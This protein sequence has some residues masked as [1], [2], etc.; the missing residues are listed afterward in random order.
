MRGLRYLF[1]AFAVVGVMVP[2]LAFHVDAGTPPYSLFYS[3]S[4]D[5][6][7]KEYDSNEIAADAKFKGKIVVVSGTIRDIGKGILGEA[8]VIIGGTGFL[9]GVQCLFSKSEESSVVRLSK[10]QYVY[11]QGKVWGKM[12]NVVIENCT[13][14]P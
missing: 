13:L 6:L 7:Y 12:G 14:Q 5:Q 3:L 9:D 11:A 10:G 2:F 4:A 8:Y 1:T